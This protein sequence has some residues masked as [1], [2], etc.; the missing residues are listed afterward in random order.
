MNLPALHGNW[1]DLIIIVVVLYFA[2]ES[3]GRG[4]WLIITDFVSFFGSLI[5]SLKT[6]KAASGLLRNNFSLNGSL[7]D[8]L[9]Y[10]IM[11][12]LFEVVLSYGVMFLLSKLPKKIWD[13]KWNKFLGLA[14]GTA[15]GLVFLAFVLTLVIA[16]PVAPNIK[17]DISNSKIGGYIIKKTSGIEKNINDIFGGVVN[18]TLTYKAIEPGSKST[19]N[20]NIESKTLVVDEPAESEMFK[21]TNE[22]RTKRGIAALTWEPGYVAIARAYATNMWQRSYFSHYS[23][24]GEDVGDRL[25]KAGIPYSIAGENLALAPTVAIAQNGL[26]NSPGHRANI[27]EPRFKKVGIGVVANGFYGLMI[28]EIFTN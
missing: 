26:M 19:V 20:L 14:L 23:P 9:G 12:L 6:Y 3:W 16:L 18:D 10:L 24:E 1:I 11:A 17:N 7:S 8:A 4:L 15:E 27:L 2:I 22:E 28:V 25:K 5:L 13:N 21:L